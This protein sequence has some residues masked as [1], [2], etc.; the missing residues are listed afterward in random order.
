MRLYGLPIL[1]SAVIATGALAGCSGTSSSSSAAS[2][3]QASTVAVQVSSS[4][5]G[6]STA[7]AQVSSTTQTSNTGDGALDTSD[8]FTDR[9]LAQVAD[10]SSAQQLTVESGKDIT[11]SEEG[12]YVISGTAEDATIV[13]D[14]DS[15]AKVQLVLNGVSITNSDAAAIFVVSADKVFVTTAA[16]STN[17]LSTTGAFATVDDTSVDGVIYAKDD[18]VLNGEGTLVIS[19]SENGIVGKDDVKI[20]GGTYKITASNHGIKGKDS[21]RIA[22]GTFEITAGKDA[23]HGENDDDPTL[24]YVYIADGNFTLN[25]ESDGIESVA[26]VQIDGGTFDIDGAEG[27]EGTYVQ[28]NGGTIDVQASDD[29]INATSKSSAYS[30][31]IEINGGDVSVSMGAGDTDALDSNG[32]L[33][34]NGGTIDIQAQS[35]FDFDG[36][37]SISGGTVTVNGQQVTELTNQ[38]MG[39]GAGGPGGMSGSGAQPGGQPGGMGGGRQGR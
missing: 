14:A 21:V 17:T 12:V 30:V 34:I 35:P 39:G 37:G 32:N 18:L 23:I 24:G 5:T 7:S 4:A 28:I 20:T 8:M 9:D 38:M 26:V 22:D 1:L 6:S 11:I 10:T 19:S 13:V 31:A 33:F 36:Q 25:A 3:V 15:S 27:I 16:G 2:S 29:G